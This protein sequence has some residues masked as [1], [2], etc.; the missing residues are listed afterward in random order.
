[1]RGGAST[2]QCLGSHRKAAALRCC[3]GTSYHGSVVLVSLSLLDRLAGRHQQVRHR[4]LNETSLVLHLGRRDAMQLQDAVPR[5]DPLAAS[6][7][8]SAGSRWGVTQLQARQRRRL[9]LR[10][11]RA[12]Q[13]APS[14]MRS[15]GF[16]VSQR[17]GTEGASAQ[18][19]VAEPHPSLP[20]APAAIASQTRVRR[21]DAVVPACPR[22]AAINVSA[23]TSPTGQP[24]CKALQQQ[25]NRVAYVGSCMLRQAALVV[26]LAAFRPLSRRALSSMSAAL[27]ASGGLGGGLLGFGDGG[28]EGGTGG[29]GCLAFAPHGRGHA[30]GSANCKRSNM[31]RLASMTRCKCP[32]AILQPLRFAGRQPVSSPLLSPNPSTHTATPTPASRPSSPPST[33]LLS[34]PPT[35]SPLLR[36][37]PEQPPTSPL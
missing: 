21:P 34:K 28:T 31:T 26:D 17:E 3:Q 29:Q 25:I 35:P 7:I 5:Q 13:C 10:C 18:Q 32:G 19:L 30:S 24:V 37:S 6:H 9:G 11:L 12:L 1:M 33:G 15:G 14:S 20:R 4:R 27:S 16:D 23:T 22:I 2:L 36:E 8:T